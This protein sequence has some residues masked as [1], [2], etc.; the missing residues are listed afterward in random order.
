MSEAPREQC[1]ACK[2]EGSIYT[3]ANE[4]AQEPETSEECSA[5][6]GTG[7]FTRRHRRI[8]GTDSPKLLHMSKYGGPSAVYRR[9]VLGEANDIDPFT[10]MRGQMMEPVTRGLSQIKYGWKLA[11]HPGIIESAEYEWCAASADDLLADENAGVEY[12]SVDPRGY[13]DWGDEGTDQVPTDYLIQCTHYMAAFDRP[14]WYICAYFGGN[15]LRRYVLQRDLDLEETWR[16]VCETFWREHVLTKTP[17]P[18]DSTPDYGEWLIRRYKSNG[19]TVSAGP[20]AEGWATRLRETKAQI[21]ALEEQEREATNHLQQLLG[22]GERMKGDGWLMR[23]QERTS[24]SWK[25]ICEE[26]GAPTELV[27]KYTGKTRYP[28]FRQEKKR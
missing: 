26:L 28:M 15:D 22:E 23:Y 1:Y 25:G 19:T 18:P 4:L 9:I 14:R 3:P 6:M 8:G 5:C 21:A 16:S 17:P 13:S 2:G 24:T 7:V 20:E 12:K 27:T 11:P 10:A